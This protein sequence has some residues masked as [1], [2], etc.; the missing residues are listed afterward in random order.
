MRDKNVCNVANQSSIADDVHHLQT[1]R[2]VPDISDFAAKI[3]QLLSRSRTGILGHSM[4]EKR[5]VDK[6]TSARTF[7]FKI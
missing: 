4:Y 5:H 7:F 2:N 3:L 6:R 1:G